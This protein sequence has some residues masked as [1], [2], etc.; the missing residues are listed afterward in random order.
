MDDEVPEEVQKILD[1]VEQQVF[2]RLNIGIDWAEL[3]ILDD[4]NASKRAIVELGTKLA[5]HNPEMSATLF[6]IANSIYFGH[7]P[8]GKAPDFFDAVIRLGADR[9]KTMI[10]AL[11]LFAMGQGPDARRRAAKSVSI[12]IMGRMIAEAMN[13]HDYLVRKVETGGLISQLGNSVF[14]KARELGMPISD[15]IIVKYQHRLAG[16]IIDKLRL[17]P[18]L[19][20]AVDLST[21]EVDEESFSPVGIIKLAEALVEDSFRRYGKLVL[22]IAAQPEKKAATSLPV[23]VIRKLF[24]TLGVED[25]F[26]VVKESESRF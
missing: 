7:N 17:D 25:F 23:E 13:L 22:R 20:Q 26:V 2:A 15:D 6:E 11:T 1:A 14:M 3:E 9:V 12:S 4:V 21:L 24:Q 18:F 10:F 5:S 19:K 16:S 8:L